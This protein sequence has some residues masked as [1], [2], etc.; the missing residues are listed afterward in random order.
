MRSDSGGSGSP[1]HGHA[2]GPGAAHLPVT[3]TYQQG[4]GTQD[5]LMAAPALPWPGLSSRLER[6]CG[7]WRHCCPR[8]GTL[9]L[10]R[11][12]PSPLLPGVYRKPSLSAHP[13]SAVAPGDD[14]TLRCHTQYN[15]DGF[16]L[17]KE[18][19]AGPHMQPEQWYRA[20]F[21]MVTVTPAHSG[22]YR[23][24]SF[25]SGSPHL[26]SAPSNPLELSV[27]GEGSALPSFLSP[28]APPPQPPGGRRAGG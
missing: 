13:S 6:S 19:D 8:L 27:S 11:L 3:P 10:P 16:A 15:F 9:P 26:W 21:P 23:C 14:V 25:S 7:E 20:D 4:Q 12:R 5:P 17:Y 18:G 22:T 1:G 2:E 24:Y 28:Q